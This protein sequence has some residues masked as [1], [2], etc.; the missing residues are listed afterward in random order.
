MKSVYQEVSRCIKL[1]LCSYDD[2]GLD[3]EDESNDTH[4]TSSTSSSRITLYVIF[5]F[6]KQVR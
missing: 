4:L 2:D 5:S 3:D 6:E 1:I